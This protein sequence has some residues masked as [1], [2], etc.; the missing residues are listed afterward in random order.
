M[1]YYKKASMGAEFAC[2]GVRPD[3]EMSPAVFDWDFWYGTSTI[4]RVYHDLAVIMALLPEA[5]DP[6]LYRTGHGM[7]VV[8]TKLVKQTD[9]N[10]LL[11]LIGAQRE[12]WYAG[13]AQTPNAAGCTVCG[14]FAEICQE[15]GAV[16][17]TGRK[18][19][20]GRDIFRVTPR[21]YSNSP[22]VDIHDAMVRQYNAKG[23]RVK[24]VTNDIQAL[25]DRIVERNNIKI[26]ANW[27]IVMPA[28]DADEELF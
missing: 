21:A 8:F 12:H 11:D 7:H 10:A 5:G 3:S 4:T 18:P 6:V 27:E 2:F 24:P 26:P 28:D 16:L 23:G 22:L 13:G 15:N 20:R 14:G 1:S 17:R 9:Y 19:N 25:V